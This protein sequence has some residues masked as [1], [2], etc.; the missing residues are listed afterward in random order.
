M[1][2][3]IPYASPELFKGERPTEKCDVY[4]FAVTMWQ[5]LHR[6]TPYENEN[7]HSVIFR[8]R[9]V[10]TTVS[11]G[12][13]WIILT[14]FDNKLFDEFQV[15][16]QGLRP[17]VT[18]SVVGCPETSDEKKLKREYAQIY[19]HAWDAIPSKRPA[20]ADIHKNLIKI[21]FSKI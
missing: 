20:M 14:W 13:F 7:Q 9:K 8:V 1:E 16:S 11:Y 4:G 17:R 18:K 15:V 5:I 10:F 19:E 12:H 2:G 21:Q 3:T 6:E